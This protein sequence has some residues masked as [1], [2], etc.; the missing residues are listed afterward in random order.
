MGI[1]IIIIIIIIPRCLYRCLTI[2]NIPIHII[3]KCNRIITHRILSIIININ[4]N[5]NMPY[6]LTI[7]NNKMDYLHRPLSIMIILTPITITMTNSNMIK[8]PLLN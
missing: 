8:L 3:T 5:I 6:N 4:I 2:N 7:T 1:I